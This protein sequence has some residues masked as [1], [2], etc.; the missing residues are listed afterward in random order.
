M[1]G[2]IVLRKPPVRE[3]GEAWSIPRGKGK[4]IMG[5]RVTS[6]NSTP[7]PAQAD[8]KKVPKQPIVLGEVT[9]QPRTEHQRVP[10]PH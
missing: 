5:T 10:L 8:P 1:I 2:C 7:A 6:G 4:N 3:I 9:P